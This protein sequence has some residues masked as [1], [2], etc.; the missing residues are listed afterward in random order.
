MNYPS[1]T[2]QQLLEENNFLKRKIRELEQ[3]ETAC[4]RAEKSRET[5]E[6]LY[7]LN[8]KLRAIGNCK[9]T[10]V[11][12]TDEQS[13]L[14]E[15]CRIVCD[16]AGH[17]MAWV[18]YAEH[19]DERTVRPIASAGFEEGYLSTINVTWA[20]SERGRGPTGTA[21]RTGETAYIQDFTADPGTTPWRRRALERGYCSSI[22]LPLKS[23]NK[24]TFGVLTIYSSTINA[25]TPEEIKLLEEMA[26]DLAFGI[27]VLRDRRERKRV[28]EALLESEIKY[29]T[30]IENSLAGVYIYQDGVFRFANKRFCEIYGY[31]A[32]EVID[33]LGPVDFAHPEERD[34]V[35]EIV[36]KCLSGERDSLT[37]RAVRKDGAAITV[38][39]LGSPMTYNGRPALSGT[40]L[41]I[42]ERERS[43]QALRESEMTLRSLINATQEA[44]LLID[45]EGKILVAN[46][47]LAQKIG[48]G[49]TEIVGTC[50]YDYFPETVRKFRKGQ[51][52]TVARTGRPVRFED[53]R[54]GRLFESYAYPV[55]DDQG[56][57]A[58]IAIFAAD[59]TARRNAE[60]GLRKSEEKYRELVETANSIILR[61]DREGR[62]TFFNEFSQRFFG[63]AREEILGKNVVGTMVPERES[64]GRDLKWLMEDI[65][66]NPDLYV[67]NVNENMRHN[68]E[69]VWIAW[70]NRPVYDALG[71]VAELLCIGNDITALRRAEETLREYERAVEGSQDIILTMNRE[72]RYLLA[73]E[74]FLRCTGL[75]K[76][77]VIGRPVAEV[78][79]PDFFEGVV[80]AN[81]DR[82]FRGELVRYE[83]KRTFLGL[84]E[85]NLLISYFPVA[86]PH[87]I[88]RVVALI[89]DVTD[90][91]RM[92]A[93]LEL[94]EEKYRSIFENA[95]E[96]IFQ[97][98]PDGRYI[99]ANPALAAMYGYESAAEMMSCVTDIQRQQYVNPE[100]RETLKKLFNGQG[101]VE[102]FE[103]QLCRKDGERVWIS[104][105][106][107]AM[108]SD[109]GRITHYE[110]TIEDITSRKKADQDRM[111]AHQRVLD[112]I[113]F[114]PD[115]TFVVN[116]ERQVVAWNKAMEEMSGVRKEDIL[117]QGD[118]AYALPFYGERK[119]V[120]IDLIFE[121]G[122]ENL[123]K[124]D[125]VEMQG[126]TLLA[127]VYVPLTYRGNGAYLS[128]R[129]SSLF[130]PSGNVIGAIESL[131]DITEQ[132]RITKELQ[133]SEERYRTAIESS[134]DAVVMIR[135]E[136]HLYVNRKFLEM[137][138][139]DNVEQ[140]LSR[141]VGFITHPDDRERVIEMSRRRQRDEKV[142]QHYEFKGVKTNGDVVFI[143]CSA[144]R[145][146]YKG[147]P[148][149]LVYLR[150][151]TG[152]ETP[153]SPA[154]SLPEDGSCGH[155]RRRRCSR[156][157]Q[158]P[159]CNHRVRKPP[160]GRH[161]E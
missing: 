134:S 143:E 149:T 148:I 128:A 15:I 87:G 54:A 57:V 81:L 121:R 106:A 60:A 107:R 30:L 95:I 28:E 80:R 157:Q 79:G 50:Q 31:T 10:L 103:T 41:D 98:T 33:R 19:D 132:K 154:P 39:V 75:R 125:H 1:E 137:F 67:S 156:F 21:V 34:I 92:E 29:R 158:Y 104:M 36:E 24:T 117:G 16:E 133:E 110:G 130:D 116:H 83:G 113:E 145:T 12:A 53:E 101:F 85:R 56:K 55:F 26:G 11:R 72:Y 40:V 94:S 78:V 13:L 82:C 71:N 61:R 96:G 65:G 141:P 25:F 7:R 37:H 5:E 20:D 120:L 140:V 3:S 111:A 46:Q 69:R 138:G 161:G 6:E 63:Y 142:P 62:V 17:R 70:T 44:L 147:E 136:E 42:T 123:K 108:R 84:G 135:G 151:V 159:H 126:D 27:M 97:T 99:S 90:Q 58:K 160:A 124:Y 8:R 112:I 129:A 48:K 152:Q 102:R 119:P 100:D 68:G 114:L 86:G 109:D 153:R 76:D 122:A 155:P 49:L 105:T 89:R 23:E 150:D 127:E 32:A 38:S 35:R 115:A 64:T 131:R 77:Q 51:Y 93:A 59:I 43:T 4:G 144:T 52:D 91:R 47:T 118:Y 88:D 74:A 45:T 9:R 139:F 22:A 66:R 146:T 18:G 2:Y 73:N 14:N